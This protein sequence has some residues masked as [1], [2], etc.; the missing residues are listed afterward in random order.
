MIAKNLDK[1]KKLSEK[2][3]YCLSGNEYEHGE[4]ESQVSFICQNKLISYGKNGASINAKKVRAP[5]INLVNTNGAGDSLLGS[6]IALKDKHGDEKA[7]EK[8]VHYSTKVCG[9][10]GPRLI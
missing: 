8:A 5:E 3:I 2:N 1:I 9:V 10:T 6:F 4:L 7:I